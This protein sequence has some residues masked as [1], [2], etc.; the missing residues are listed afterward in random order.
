MPIMQTSSLEHLN[1]YIVEVEVKISL[2]PSPA[3]LEILC[4]LLL[5]LFLDVLWDKV[6]SIGVPEVLM[7]KRDGEATAV[8]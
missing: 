7:G 6:V 5:L 1:S 8:I 2:P 4:Y 3:S